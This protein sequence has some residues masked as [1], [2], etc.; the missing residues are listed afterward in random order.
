[1]TIFFGHPKPMLLGADVHWVSELF[2]LSFFSSCK[3][4]QHIVTTIDGSTYQDVSTNTAYDNFWH[5]KIALMWICCYNEGFSIFIIFLLWIW[6]TSGGPIWLVFGPCFINH[7]SRLVVVGTVTRVLIKFT[8]V[9]DS[10][11]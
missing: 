1:M 9:V 7:F 5:C 2:R 6:L 4:R 11:K 3:N 8:L 10:N